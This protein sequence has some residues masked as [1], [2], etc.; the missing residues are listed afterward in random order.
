[1]E[2][3]LLRE[4]EREIGNDRCPVCDFKTIRCIKE[5]NKIKVYECKCGCTWEI[6]K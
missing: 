4:I 5:D 2:E 1:M 3:I 6:K